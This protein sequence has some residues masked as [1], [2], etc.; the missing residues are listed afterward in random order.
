MYITC[1]SPRS[2][3]ACLFPLSAFS[4]PQDP[5]P[6]PPS[7][8][9]QTLPTPGSPP[10][11]PLS[12]SSRQQNPGAT[13][14]PGSSSSAGCEFHKGGCVS[15]SPGPPPLHPQGP[16]PRVLPSCWPPPTCSSAGTSRPSEGTCKAA[17]RSSG[18][19]GP[20]S[21]VSWAQKAHAGRVWERHRAQASHIPRDQGSKG[22]LG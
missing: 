18:E 2:T 19:R 8:F 22:T 1:I 5:F 6:C 16:R 13:H 7:A 21:D 17:H 4:S 14:K 9:I 10:S 3:N 20:P 15:S 11:P 12:L